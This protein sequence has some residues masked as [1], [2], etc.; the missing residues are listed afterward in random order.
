MYI[1]VVIVFLI[2]IE[3]TFQTYIGFYTFLIKK[4][5]IPLC[6]ALF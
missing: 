2:D 1:T 4:N 3:I 6:C 5:L